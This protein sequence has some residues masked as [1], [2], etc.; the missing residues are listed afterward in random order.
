MSYLKKRHNTWYARLGVPQSVRPI[1]RRN[2]FVRSLQTTS[3]SVAARRAVAYVAEWKETIALAL[4]TDELKKE[5]KWW[6]RA[7]LSAQSEERKALALDLISDKAHSYISRDRPE[8]AERFHGLA[9]GLIVDLDDYI[10]AWRDYR[11]NEVSEKEANVAMKRVERMA[12]RFKESS[13]V[14]RKEVW[15]YPDLSDT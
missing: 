3:R 12:E 8:D 10:E 14:S 6:R 11:L 4:S 13:K 5:A 9:M 2:E 1:L 15:F 7:F